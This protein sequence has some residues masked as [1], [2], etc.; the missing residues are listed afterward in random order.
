MERRMAPNLFVPS[1][2]TLF[3]ARLIFSMEQLRDIASSSFR[4]NSVSSRQPCSDIDLRH[5]LSRIVS[6]SSASSSGV[7][8][9]YLCSPKMHAF[10]KSAWRTSLSISMKNSTVWLSYSAPA[11]WPKVRP[12]RLSIAMSRDGSG[13]RR[14]SMSVDRLDYQTG[15]SSALTSPGPGQAAVHFLQ[16]TADSTSRYGRGP[17]GGGNR[18]NGSSWKTAGPL[19]C[20]SSTCVSS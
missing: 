5:E 15:F 18:M 19:P 1:S 13:R 16:T 2:P 14:E 4:S 3:P 20:I 11:L 8:G 9:Q 12:P 17:A 10:F 7:S 6:S